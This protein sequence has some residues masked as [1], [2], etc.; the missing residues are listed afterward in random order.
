MKKIGDSA[1]TGV[2]TFP[3][4]SGWIIFIRNFIKLPVRT[5]INDIKYSLY[6]S[7]YLLTRNNTGG[8]P[9]IRLYKEGLPSNYDR[10]VCFFSS[11]D[12]ESIVRKSVYYYLNELVLAGFDIVFVSSS[13]A[14]L[15]ED[16]RKLSECCIRIINRENKGYDFYSWKIGLEKYP[17]Y[18]SHTALLL[19]NDSVWGPIF[20]IKNLI[21]RLENCDADI[22]GMTDCFLM[23]PHLQSYFLYCKKNV[24]ISEEFLHFFHEIVALDSKEVVIREYEVGFCRLLAHKFRI[25]SLY[26]LE[27]IMA[28]IGHHATGA[29]YHE[30]EFKYYVRSNK[31]IEP[32]TH[33]WRHFVTEYKFPFIKKSLMTRRG[34]NAEEILKVLA[35]SGSTYNADNLT[36]W[37]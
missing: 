34:I 1:P 22:V 31:Q 10:P 2:T 35:E 26:R 5:L 11:Y 12:D 16:L 13:D 27:S 8:R 17:N 36:D 9:M 6:L 3:A 20:G 30:D 21:G 24:V 15:E 33:L 14:I 37:R 4:V 23:H 25:T 7:F 28:K 18:N 29:K 19:A 32:M